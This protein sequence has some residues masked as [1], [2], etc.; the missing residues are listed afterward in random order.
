MLIQ[1][2]ALWLNFC[3][4]KM[5]RYFFLGLHEDYAEENAPGKVS[6]SQGERPALQTITNFFCYFCS[7]FISHFSIP[8]P[9]INVN[10]DP[11]SIRNTDSF[12]NH[13]SHGP[14]YIFYN[15]YWGDF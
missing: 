1:I 4:Q 2:Q 15:I 10:P 7:F 14:F 13:V 5:E 11:V 6:N 12:P 3:L 8:D 9:Q